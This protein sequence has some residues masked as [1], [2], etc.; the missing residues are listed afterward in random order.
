MQIY[1]EETDRAGK[2]RDEAG[3]ALFSLEFHL[4]SNSTRLKLPWTSFH[5]KS[6]LVPAI[7]SVGWSCVHVKFNH[8]QREGKGRLKFILM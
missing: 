5:I 4:G 7:L 1:S 2:Q 8:I 6:A 3:L